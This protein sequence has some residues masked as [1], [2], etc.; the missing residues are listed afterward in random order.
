[1]GLDLSRTTNALTPGKRW[2][3]CP[4]WR[5]VLFRST[6]ELSTTD[7]YTA[8]EDKRVVHPWQVVHEE[9]IEKWRKAQ[10]NVIWNYLVC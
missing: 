10:S 7:K 2:I 4:E 6:N 5:D 3:R 8:E 1:M 9:P